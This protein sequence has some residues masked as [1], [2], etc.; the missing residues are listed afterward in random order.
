MVAWEFWRMNLEGISGKGGTHLRG[1]AMGAVDSL[2]GSGESSRIP[3][4]GVSSCRKAKEDRGDVDVEVGS[5]DEE[6]LSFV[7]LVAILRV[8]SSSRE[9]HFLIVCFLGD[10]EDGNE[11]GVVDKV[12]CSDFAE[13]ACV[14]GNNDDDDDDIAGEYWEFDDN[15]AYEDCDSF[16]GETGVV[17]DEFVGVE[18]FISLLVAGC[19]VCFCSCVNRSCVSRSRSMMDLILFREE[20]VVGV[21]VVGVLSGFDA[22]DDTISLFVNGEARLGFLLDAPQAT[23]GVP[24]LEKG[25]S[26]PADMNT[27]SSHSSVDI[28]DDDDV[29]AEDGE[30]EVNRPSVAIVE[31]T[32][33]SISKEDKMDLTKSLDGDSSWVINGIHEAMSSC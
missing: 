20:G 1:I 22:A 17:E 28:V 13:I 19:G 23:L 30:G 2:S 29:E 24:E 33:S 18:L 16:K 7:V 31:P 25:F 5:E 14:A 10:V 27:S 15:D 12:V 11:D 3:R 6:G 4:E 8:T 21:G 32:E 26:E 9:N